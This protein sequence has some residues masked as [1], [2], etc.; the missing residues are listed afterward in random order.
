VKAHDSGSKPRTGDT[1]SWMGK[2]QLPCRGGQHVAFR[3]LRATSY[4]PQMLLSLLLES[5]GHL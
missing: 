5:A 3:D 4:N 1:P 2:K